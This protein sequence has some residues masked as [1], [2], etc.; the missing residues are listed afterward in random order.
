[1]AQRYGRYSGDFAAQM[2]Q[3]AQDVERNF[4]DGVKHTM[5][6]VQETV[7]RLTPVDTGRA[8]NGFKVSE[9]APDLGAPQ[10]IGPF[11]VTGEYRII[12]NRKVIEAA[13]GADLDFYFQNTVPYVPELNAGSSAQAPAGFIE[14]GIEAGMSAAKKIEV[15]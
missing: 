10:M 13:Q 2:K 9:G 7:I 6:V 11:D 3:I 14:Q 12:E 8:R 4:S 1:M 5:D 15:L